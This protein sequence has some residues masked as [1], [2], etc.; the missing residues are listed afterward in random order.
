M[1]YGL[2]LSAT[3][4]AMNQ[5]RQDVIANNLAN[6]DTVGFK[7]DVAVFKQRLSEAHI[8]PSGTRFLPRCYRR[9]TGG[10]FV[11]QVHTDYSPGPT[12][13]TSKS[14]DIALDG[15]GM[16][17]VRNGAGSAYTRDGRLALADG[18]L[19]R[20][21]DGRAVLSADGDQISVGSAS[22]QQLH[23]DSDG[24]LYRGDE[25]L[26]RLGIVEFR[27]LGTVTKLGGDLF[28]S[29]DPP[30]AAEQTQVT[31]GAVEASGVNPANELV[32]MIKTARIFQ[33]NAQMIS[34]QDQ[35]LARLVNELPRL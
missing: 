10:G 8:S 29:S 33:M 1:L 23:I 11:S 3:G 19:V 34:M 6:V 21:I 13:T 26:A 17:T 28:G 20:A 35:S 2:Y 7:R 5:H 15:P 16:L 25:Q 18:K 24:Y 31:S 9:M 27:D 12:Q 30:I 22:E 32:D 14:L 4:L